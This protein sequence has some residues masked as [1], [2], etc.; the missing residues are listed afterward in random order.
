MNTRNIIDHGAD[1]SRDM[2]DCKYE[3][4]NIIGSSVLISPGRWRAV[5]RKTR[6]VIGYC[7]DNSME[8]SS[9][10]DEGEKYHGKCNSSRE[11]AGSGHCVGSFRAIVFRNVEGDKYHQPQR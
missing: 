10:S 7:V 8:I 6:T 3:G 11:I 9:C 5:M 4:E 2:S 1:S